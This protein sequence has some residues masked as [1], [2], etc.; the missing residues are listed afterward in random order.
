MAGGAADCAYFIRLLEKECKVLQLK[1]GVKQ[2][3]VHAVAKI[4]SSM[5]RS[6][7]GAGKKQHLFTKNIAF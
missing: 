4:L 5:L 6:N 2:L 1:L 7:R 3:S